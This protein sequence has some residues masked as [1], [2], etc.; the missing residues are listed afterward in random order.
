M[1]AMNT[2]VL[3]AVNILEIGTVHYF[4]LSWTGNVVSKHGS[5][6]TGVFLRISRGCVLSR[7]PPHPQSDLTQV[8]HKL[9]LFA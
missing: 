1:I 4:N 5:S 2:A 7:H 6:Q 9:N 3:L 8:T